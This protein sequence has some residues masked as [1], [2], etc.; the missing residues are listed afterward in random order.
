[1]MEL[2]TVTLTLDVS[3]G[4]TEIRLSQEFYTHSGRVRNDTEEILTKGAA[5]LLR[6]Y[7]ALPEVAQ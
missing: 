4:D 1:M 7:S 6:R 2:G 3:V 5:E